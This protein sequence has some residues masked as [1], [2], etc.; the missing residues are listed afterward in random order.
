MNPTRQWR[1]SRKITHHEE[2]TLTIRCHCPRYLT[3]E[4]CLTTLGIIERC[5][6][7]HITL[8]SCG[9]EWT[10]STML[11]KSSSNGSAAAWLP[12]LDLMT[13]LSFL[14]I[15]R[16]EGA[17]VTGN[18]FDGA[19]RMLRWGP[20]QNRHG[21]CHRLHQCLD[22]AKTRSRRRLCKRREDRWEEEGGLGF[23][24]KRHDVVLLTSCGT[25]AIGSQLLDDMY[26]R[27]VTWAPMGRTVDRTLV[28]HNQIHIGKV[29][30]DWGCCVFYTWNPSISHIYDFTPL[31]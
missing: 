16:D 10:M 5:W 29:D 7:S 21:V 3:V 31:W 14:Q 23:V 8:L 13:A 12:A 22:L 17:G 25:C 26:R 9:W 6:M 15:D 24:G 18:R 28:T 20:P 1:K 2:R 30:V 4:G 27:E 11:D 19:T